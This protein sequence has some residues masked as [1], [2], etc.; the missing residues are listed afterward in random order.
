MA[1]IPAYAASRGAGVDITDNGPCWSTASAGG[2]TF[3]PGT[4]NFLFVRSTNSG[5]V[6]V[7]VI[8]ASGTGGP[9]GTFLA[10]MALAP[11]VGANTG[12]RIYGPFPS[13]SFADASDGQVH[14]VYSSASNVQVS[15]LNFSAA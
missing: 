6:T 11:A 3:P 14:M 4:D 15:V 10:P 9:S 13:S 7:T 8:A 1:A 2:D 5:A 12:R